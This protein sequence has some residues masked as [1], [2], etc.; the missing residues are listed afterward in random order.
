MTYEDGYRSAW[1]LCDVSKATWSDGARVGHVASASVT[2]SI[3]SDAPSIDSADVEL[4]AATPAVGSYV[5]LWMD[6]RQSGALA[7]VPIVTGRVAPS[8]GEVM[9]TL[10]TKSDVSLES[11]LKPAE[12]AKMDEGWH[13]PQGTDGAAIAATLLRMHVDAPVIIDQGA[14]PLLEESVVAG[15]DTVLSVAWALVG[16]AWEIATDGMGVV[17][18]R[19]R[20]ATTATIGAEVLCSTLKEGTSDDRRTLDYTREWMDGVGVGAYVRVAGEDGLWRVVSQRIN[21]GCGATVDETV[22]EV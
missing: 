14:R 3:D 6:A 21:C 16:D 9:G 17:H 8:S 7:R 12:D 5:R 1:R 10:R 22:K 11:V 4:S 2:R 20:G 18:L 15:T 19:P 13:A